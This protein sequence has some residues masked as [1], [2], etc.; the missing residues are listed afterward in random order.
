[1]YHSHVFPD[2]G[3]LEELRALAPQQD[4]L[5]LRFATLLS[6]TPVALVPA[7][8]GEHQEA[9]SVHIGNSRDALFATFNVGGGNDAALGRLVAFCARRFGLDLSA[10][11]V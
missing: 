6:R 11:H 2:H 8:P 7:E 5:A 1:M 10:Y 4:D 9:S 3:L